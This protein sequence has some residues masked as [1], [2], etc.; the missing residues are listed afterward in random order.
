MYI[1]KNKGDRTV[2]DNS[3]GIALFSVAGKVLARVLLSSLIT[4][5]IH[6]AIPESQYG[7]RKERST[8][9]LTFIL[10]QL[11]AKYREQNQE[12][13]VAFVDLT[14]AFDIVNRDM[15]WLVMKKFGCPPQ[16]VAVLRAFHDGMEASVS[17][18][19]KT[20]SDKFTV[21]VGVR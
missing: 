18:G 3:R 21:N 10:R 4:H 8:N 20:S 12:L 7:I 19:G 15:L 2:C 13:Y 17:V 16:F 11:Q 5:V 6:L 9:D 1:Y 14:K